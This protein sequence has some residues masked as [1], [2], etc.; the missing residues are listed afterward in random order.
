M[1]RRGR[2]N[3]AQVAAPVA[4]DEG[5]SATAEPTEPELTAEPEPELAP[6]AVELDPDRPR[7]WRALTSL[8]YTSTTGKWVQLLALAQGPEG[9]EH[10]IVD[11]MPLAVALDAQA[12]GLVEPV[13]PSQGAPDDGTD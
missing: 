7:R 10:P 13:E 2:F 5:P 4:A 6:V 12:R 3:G 9:W 1:A 11:D 8:T